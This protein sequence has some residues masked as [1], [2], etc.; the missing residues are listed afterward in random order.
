MAKYF[1]LFINLEHKRV[2]VVGGGMIATRRVQSLLEFGCHILVISPDITTDLQCL[3]AKQ[4]IEWI[5]KEYEESL[6]HKLN[7]VVC[8]VGATN[9]RDVNH[10]VYLDAKKNHICV[11]ICDV[12]EECDFY[13][14]GV[15]TG[16]NIVVGITASGTNH[17]LAK[18]VTDKIR[19]EKKELIDCYEKIDT[20]GE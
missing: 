5:Q 3:A 13:F 19:K 12:K 2:I 6:W 17:K 20:S 9:Q 14:P 4:K 1:P 16:T 15:V 10:L 8:M 18:C 7:D 11:N